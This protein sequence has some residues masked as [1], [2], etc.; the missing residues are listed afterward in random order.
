VRPAAPDRDH[1]HATSA[2]Y[3]D[4]AVEWWDEPDGSVGSREV[5]R[6]SGYFGAPPRW[7]NRQVSGV[8]VVNQLEPSHVHLAEATMWPHPGAEHPVPE[9]LGLPA[10]TVLFEGGR[11]VTHPAAVAGAAH[12]GLPEPWPP[13][14][15]WSDAG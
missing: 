2:L 10:D 5:R 11:I 14:E 15:P 4:A 3:G 13:G 1:W 7:R 6:P 9:H 12:F 8:L